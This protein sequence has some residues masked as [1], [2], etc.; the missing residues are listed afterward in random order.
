MLQRYAARPVPSDDTTCSLR[1][2]NSVQSVLSPENEVELLQGLVNNRFMVRV[3][4]NSLFFGLNQAAEHEAKQSP[5]GRKDEMKT[6]VTPS[7]LPPWT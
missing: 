2:D 3:R 4:F 1:G 5:I 6:Q 7:F